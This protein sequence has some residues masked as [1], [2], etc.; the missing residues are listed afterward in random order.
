MKGRIERLPP[1]LVVVA[2]HPGDLD[3]IDRTRRPL[4]QHLIMHEAVG[5]PSMIRFREGGGHR[6]DVLVAAAPGYGGTR[7][8]PVEELPGGPYAVADYEGD[9]DGVEQ[10]REAFLAWLHGAGHAPAGPLVQVH[11]M[12][13]VDGIT[14]QQFQVPVRA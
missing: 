13:P 4:Y 10:A 11:L 1:R 3:S 7:D 14:E 6:Y 2:A 12:D 8:F 9:P 5:G